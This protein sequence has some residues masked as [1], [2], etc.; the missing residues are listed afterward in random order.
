MTVPTIL[1]Y[2]AT[3]EHEHYLSS[4]VQVAGYDTQLGG[5]T[6]L[7]AWTPEQF[8]RHVLPY[9]AMHIDQDPNASDPLADWLDVEAGAASANE[10][11]NWIGRARASYSQ[12]LRADQR[13][14][15]IY[16]SE[17]NLTS[18]VALLQQ[19]QVTN[20]PFWVANYNYTAAQAQQAVATAMGPYPRI[21]HQYT[22][23][24]SG[25]N[26][27]ASYFSLPYVQNMAVGPIIPTED[28]MQ[29]GQFQSQAYLPF[30]VGA[31]KTV[32]LYRDFVSNTNSV[33]VRLAIHSASKG[34]NVIDGAI[35][36][37]T[38]PH[39]FDFTETDVDAVSMVV[40]KGN[41]PVG[42]YLA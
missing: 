13:W 34:Y 31:F 19:A 10:I 25:G 4:T 22:D 8:A 37:T 17:S 40:S 6:G 26:V 42:Y 12:K 11:V 41:G 16:L 9:P 24:I 2:D 7:I 33:T 28:D 23:Q 20:V 14:P 18:A 36:E 27:D 1:T 35:L 21:G 38:I 5:G 32:G 3:S 30:P 15:G 29:F 39:I